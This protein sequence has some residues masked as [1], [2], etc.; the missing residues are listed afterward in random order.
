MALQHSYGASPLLPS[1]GPCRAPPPLPA[2]SVWFS[3]VRSILLGW[4]PQPPRPP[5]AWW[6]ASSCGT[7]ITR[8]P[9]RCIQKGECDR[10][11]ASTQRTWCPPTRRHAGWSR[12]RVCSSSGSP[13]SWAWRQDAAAPACSPALPPAAP[14][15]PRTVAALSLDCCWPPAYTGSHIRDTNVNLFIC[16]LDIWVSG[17][18]FWAQNT[19]MHTDLDLLI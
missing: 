18:L 2:A 4:L 7:H 10:G 5:E 3:P 14:S 17:H 13:R 19:H 15:E 11:L 8:C 6:P 16:T 9:L 1:Q 12:P